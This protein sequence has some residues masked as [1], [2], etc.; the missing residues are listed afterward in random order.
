MVLP[1]ATLG[2]LGG[3]QLG[4]M[5]VHAATAM[6]YRVTVLDPSPDS[7]AGEIAHSHLQADY[8]DE[9]AL[10]AL[11]RECAVVTTEFENV[12]AQVL[13]YLRD[14]CCVYPSPEA[15]SVAQCRIREKQYARSLDIPCTAFQ[16]V[17][18]DRDI[19]QAFEEI[20]ADLILKTDRFGYDGK[21]QVCVSSVEQAMEAWK[22]LDQAECILEKRID[23]RT[24][25]SCVLARSSSGETS[26]FTIAENLHRDGILFTSTVPAGVD[27]ATQDL[28][29]SHARKI[30]EDLDYCGVLAVEYF[31]DQGNTLYFNEMAPRTHNSGHY[32]I[33]ACYTS[34][35]EQQVRAV[36]GLSLGSAAA[37]SAVTMVNLLGDLWQP[38][39]PRWGDLMEEPSVKLHLYGKKQ[40]RPGRKMGHFCVLAPPGEDTRARAEQLFS[41]L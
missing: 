9:Q 23:L 30:A 28:A 11:A 15:V 14:G 22:G 1:G 8:T 20:G 38:A 10:D 25:I 5:F 17:R 36:C 29:R 12:P 26:F 2:M 27:E 18:S 19:R 7:P 6:G 33:D 16:P 37:H 4:R 32:T 24:E 3:G 35:F 40:A 31:V 34:Q 41:R 13:Q 21:G 39:E